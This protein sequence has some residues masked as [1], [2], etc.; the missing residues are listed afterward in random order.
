M[1]RLLTAF[2]EKEAWV[3]HVGTQDGEG[4]QK[5]LSKDLCS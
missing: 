5:A 4:I 1:S 3:D 2:L